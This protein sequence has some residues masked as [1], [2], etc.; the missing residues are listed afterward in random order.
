[1]W[2]LFLAT[3]PSRRGLVLATTRLPA[4]SP[5]GRRSRAHHGSSKTR[6][7]FVPQ[8]ALITAGA[9]TRD[10]RTRQHIPAPQRPR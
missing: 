2:A 10:K 4:P 8:T 6:I 3:V 5:L 1:M 7:P 9:A